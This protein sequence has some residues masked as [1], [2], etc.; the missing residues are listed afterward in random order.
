MNTDS[1][2]DPS[3]VTKMASDLSSLEI[4]YYRRIVRVPFPASSF[5]L[6]TNEDLN[7]YQKS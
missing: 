2:S 6:N 7:R 1:A 3:E 5:D 4:S